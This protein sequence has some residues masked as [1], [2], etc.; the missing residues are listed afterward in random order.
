MKRESHYVQTVLLCIAMLGFFLACGEPPEANLKAK[1]AEVDSVWIKGRALTRNLDSLQAVQL[2]LA[3]K[4]TKRVRIERADTEELLPLAS[5]YQVLSEYEKVA[6]ALRRYLAA[7]GAEDSLAA[8]RLMQ[9]YIYGDMPLRAEEFIENEAQNYR[10]HPTF[11]DF[12][13]LAM[14]FLDQGQHQKAE[15]WA[16]RAAE[17]ADP[18]IAFRA[19]SLKADV[20]AGAGEYD[21]AKAILTAAIE[22]NRENEAV[23]ETLGASLLRLQ[24]MNSPAPEILASEWLDSSPLTLADLRGKVVLLDFWATWCAPCRVTFPHLRE[25]YGAY[26][27]KGLEII[28]LTAYYAMFNQLGE[29]L[30][31]LGAEEELEWV[32][33]FKAHHEMP[34]PYA[35][36]NDEQAA[37][38]FESYGV[39]GI[40][41]MVVIDTS[42]MIRLIIVGSGER[43]SRLLEDKIKELLEL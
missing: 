1:A 2:E 8:V 22:E 5:L 12:Y 21:R 43:N 13:I 15:K 18:R 27:E 7:P 38:N 11:N 25:M 33:K 28:G 41:T 6:D 30:R 4:Y 36:A 19:I 37:H 39:Q 34:F 32:K 20:A 17:I 31:N 14:G 3:G 42:G 26:H 23:R 24:L 16:E 29:N 35:I 9:T 40:P 10:L